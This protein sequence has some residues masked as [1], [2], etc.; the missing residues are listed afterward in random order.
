MLCKEL[1]L[2]DEFMTQVSH[3]IREQ[4]QK[5]QRQAMESGR[6]KGFDDLSNL[7]KSTRSLLESSSNY[8]NLNMKQEQAHVLITEHNYLRD[9]Q[10]I[11][12][13][14]S[15]NLCSWEPRVEMLDP[16][17]IRRVQKTEDRKIRY[18]T[19]FLS[20]PLSSVV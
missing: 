4:V 7:K 19:L 1:G 12:T 16:E 17:D 18:Y 5:H 8:T 20:V 15:D 10:R 13:D 3:S 6:Y 11:Y 14:L 9:L 2:N